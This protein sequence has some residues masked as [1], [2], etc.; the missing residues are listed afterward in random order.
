MALPNRLRIIVPGGFAVCILGL[1]AAWLKVNSVFRETAPHAVITLI[2]HVLAAPV[3]LVFEWWR[4]GGQSVPAIA[5][6]P[7]VVAMAAIPFH[8]I[9]ARRWAAAVTIVG[10]IF[11]LFCEFIVAGAPA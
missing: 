10:L 3:F 5:V 1:G 6:G 8:P 2:G 7:A 11:W 9:V 4:D